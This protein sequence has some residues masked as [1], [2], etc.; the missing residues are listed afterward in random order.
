MNVTLRKKGYDVYK[1]ER[2]CHLKLVTTDTDFGPE[3]NTPATN[4][5][6]EELEHICN[7][8]IQSLQLKWN[9]LLNL[10]E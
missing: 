2:W 1:K 4:T 8:Y 9:K 3:A 6:Q 10:P 5:S 7:E